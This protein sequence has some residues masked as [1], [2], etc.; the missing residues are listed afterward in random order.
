MC[1]KQY[2]GR[3]VQIAFFVGN[4]IGVLF[5]G[6]FSDWFGRKTAY[7]TTLTLWMVFG[8]SGYFAT[9]RYVW[10]IIRFFCGAMSLSFNT[11]KSVYCL[12]LTS[13]KWKSRVAHYF[14]ELP[15]Q[16][17][18]LTLGLL[19]YIIP[20]MQYLE[21]FI[22]LT[23][24]MFMPLWFILPESPRWLVSK[25]KLEQA[26]K[27][28]L[29]A[30]KWNK[31]PTERVEKEIETLAL[32]QTN[33]KEKEKNGMMHD[34]FKPPGVRR[35]S[36]VIIFCWLAFSMGYFGLIYNTPSFDANIYLVFVVPAM[37]GIPVSLFQP[38]FDN[39]FGRKKMMTIPLVT[40]GIVLLV[41]TGIPKGDSIGNWS[42]IILAWIGTCCC[43]MAFGMGYI[44]TLEL[45]PTLYRTT[46]LGMAS[47]GA[48]V[49]SLLSPLI[50][51]LSVVHP[52]LPLGVY[53]AIVLAAGISS[54]F[55]WPETLNMNFTETLEECEDLASTPNS[56]LK[57][58]SFSN[59]NKIAPHDEP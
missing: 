22:G 3:K 35:N 40:A 50:A 29:T 56:W 8:I 10:L 34:L 25:G 38:Y 5:L 55:L 46:A 15:W 47:A 37:V 53:G 58:S 4:M 54:I 48:R 24:L 27:V 39:K 12:E 28:L 42:V 14:G 13:G 9:N 31:K 32:N 45:Y 16:L 33:G 49:G 36:I 6:S 7:M 43:G 52:V 20:N 59:K 57:C 18:H 1:E 30:C 41:T 44:F 21:L 19:I 23:A 17:G 11:A 26:K 51:M 2:F